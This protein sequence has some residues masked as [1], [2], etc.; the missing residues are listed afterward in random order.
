MLK[1]TIAP[2]DMQ[3]ILELEGRLNG[4]WVDELRYCWE[5]ARVAGR[6]ITVLLKQVSF[7][8]AAGKHLLGEMHRAGALL[9]AEGCMTK[10]IVDEIIGGNNHE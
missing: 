1:I 4:P 7:I 2:D 8:D 3:T 10:A 9:S 6:G 5:G